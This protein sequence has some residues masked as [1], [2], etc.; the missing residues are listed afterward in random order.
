MIIC[1]L[2]KNEDVDAVRNTAK[3]AGLTFGEKTILNIPVSPTGE[4]PATHWFCTFNASPETYK[5]I[6][7]IQKL[8]DIDTEKTRNFLAERNLKIIADLL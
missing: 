2:A 7:E 8:T 1:I 5:K 3:E 4:L 6:K